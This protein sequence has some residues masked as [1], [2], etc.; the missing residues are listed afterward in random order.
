MDFLLWSILKWSKMRIQYYIYTNDTE[1]HIMNILKVF[2]FSICYK[3]TLI[4][5]P[6]LISSL[7]NSNQIPHHI[8]KE[9]QGENK[10]KK[11][12]K[13]LYNKFR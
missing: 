12:Y 1:L 7:S 9:K 13:F 4:F 5:L 6:Q 2:K 3:N 11:L 10:E 8:K